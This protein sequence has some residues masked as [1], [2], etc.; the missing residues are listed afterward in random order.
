MGSLPLTVLY[1]D[2][3]MLVVDK[4]VGMHTAPLRPDETGTLLDR[5]IAVF[6]EVAGLP[7]VKKVEPGLVHRLDRDTS[8]LVV[9]ARTADAFAALR[10]QFASGQARKS[11]LAA[12]AVVVEEGP[13]DALRI[14]SRFAPYGAG[15]KMVRVV[16]PE[17]TR[18]RRSPTRELY[19]TEATIIARAAG[20]ALILAR[21]AKGFRHQVRAHLAFLGYPI[22]GDLLYGTP[23]PDGS[24]PRMYLHASEIALRHPTTQAGFSV[25]SPIPSEFDGLFPGFSTDFRK[26]ASR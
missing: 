12:C 20:R 18:I 10:D 26:G 22:L 15:R 3:D 14:E 1:Q 2:A 11:Y 19:T 25:S 13:G 24:P 6:P 21:I 4:P 9:V 23:V 17:E 8:G 16:L 7:G 5:V